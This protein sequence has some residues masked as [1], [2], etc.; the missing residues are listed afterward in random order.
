MEHKP[1][2][3]QLCFVLG[4]QVLIVDFTVEANSDIAAAIAQFLVRYPEYQTAL[5]LP[6]AGVAV[7][8]KLRALTDVVR[9]GDRIE[10]CGP[11]IATPM[12]ARRRRAQREHKGGKM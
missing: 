9:A 2:A 11:L 8:G 1:I 4:D 10:I 6:N 12:D 5:S 7:F 3:V